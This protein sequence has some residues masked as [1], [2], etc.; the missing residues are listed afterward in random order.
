LHVLY[1]KSDSRVLDSGGNLV[2]GV[3]RI[4]N[5]FQ[6]D[7]S[8]VQSSLR[9]LLSQP[10]FKLWKW[11]RRLGHLSFD[12]LYRLSGLGLLLELS[13]LKFESDLV[14]A[15]C[16][17]GKMIAAS[18]SSINTVMTKLPRQ[19]LHMDTVSPSQIHS[20]GGKWYILV[21]V[22][23]YSW[24]SWVF[25]LE[26]KDG[27]FEHFQSLAL[28]LNNEHPNYLKV[29][30]RDNGTEFSNASFD[31]F[32]L[33][34]SVERKNRTLVEMARTMLDEHRT[35]RCFWANAIS[36]ACYISNQIFLCSILHLTPFELRFG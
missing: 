16:C 24:Y 10:S 3:S 4:K 29:I 6:A 23:D 8:L 33:E 20:I 15:S 14:C 1:R 35:H 21:I 9:S 17:H 22:D 27:V 36:T 13:L 7:F 31:Q 32:C 30:R 2:C 12:L 5:V 19:L 18:H 28:R 34:H 25:F 11:H 26:S